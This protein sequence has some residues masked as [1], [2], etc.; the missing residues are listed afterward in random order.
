MDE[1]W[2]R[3][4][5]LRDSA[6]IVNGKISAGI[7][8]RNVSEVEMEALQL[9]EIAREMFHITDQIPME[10]LSDDETANS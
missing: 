10:G 2:K 4:Q 5:I 1:L 3:L 9:E 7:A 8:A 6:G